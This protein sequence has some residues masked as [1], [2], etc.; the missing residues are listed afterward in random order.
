LALSP[1]TQRSFSPATSRLSPS[2]DVSPSAPLV[3]TLTT[4]RLVRRSIDSSTSWAATP[5]LSPLNS[6][7][8]S[9]K[10]VGWIA[11][12]LHT[13]I[14]PLPPVRSTRSTVTVGSI[15]PGLAAAGSSGTSSLRRWT[16]N[17]RLR[18]A[19]LSSAVPTPSRAGWMRR[20]AAMIASAIPVAV[21]SKERGSNASPPTNA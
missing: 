11:K 9:P 14:V 16:S 21:T 17:S 10:D 1:G 5:A 8:P 3:H 4:P 18:D 19:S 7:L 13:A 12:L 6:E 15:E 20:L 2:G